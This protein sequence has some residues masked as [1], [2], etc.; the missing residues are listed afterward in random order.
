MGNCGSATSRSC[1]DSCR[2][3]SQ[4]CHIVDNLRPATTLLG[5][6]PDNPRKEALHL[7]SRK[8]RLAGEG[9][10]EFRAPLPQAAICLNFCSV[11][12]SHAE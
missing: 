11:T 2:C 4:V 8:V 6:C 3:H 5:R 10:E 9:A 7:P 12:R 1:H